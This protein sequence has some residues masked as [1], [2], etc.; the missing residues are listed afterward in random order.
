MDFLTRQPDGAGDLLAYLR[1]AV[2]AGD[3]DRWSLLIAD[4]VHTL[5]RSTAN[6]GAARC[7]DV[8]DTHG[9]EST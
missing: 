6:V 2:K 9:S 8:F 1:A 3:Q 4:Q 7:S 5:M